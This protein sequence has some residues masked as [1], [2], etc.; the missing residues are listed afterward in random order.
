MSLLRD[1]S[2]QKTSKPYTENQNVRPKTENTQQLNFTD[3][4]I[5]I[6]DPDKSRENNDNYIEPIIVTDEN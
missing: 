3:I 6:S 2:L 5:F 1:N 4:N